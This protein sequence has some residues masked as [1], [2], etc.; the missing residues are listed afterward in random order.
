MVLGLLAPALQVFGVLAPI[1]AFE[2]WGLQALGSVL[3]LGGLAGTLYAQNDMGDSWRI[4]VDPQE[5]T[6]LVRRGAF[7]VVHQW[8]QKV[9][10]F[11]GYHKYN[12][13]FV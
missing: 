2:A 4:G 11:L 13:R 6:T 10:S 3:A 7:A 1:A 9:Q 12:V 8:L 5:S